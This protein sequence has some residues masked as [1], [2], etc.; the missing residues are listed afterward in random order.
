FRPPV[1]AAVGPAG[2]LVAP[3]A[4]GGTAPAVLLALQEVG[5]APPPSA[6]PQAERDR[7]ARRHGAALLK[8]LRGL[9]LALLDGAEPD[10]AR[11]A[12]LAAL[13]EDEEAV[14]PVLREAIAA[15]VLRARVE[16]ARR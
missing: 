6:A 13:A 16:L 8:A 11:L 5:N 12:G 2:P 3:A 4:A 7:R 9:Q 15:I 1:G 10:A 14:D